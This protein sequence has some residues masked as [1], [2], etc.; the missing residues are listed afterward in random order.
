MRKIHFLSFCPRLNTVNYFCGLGICICN[1]FICLPLCIFY[2]R[3][4]QFTCIKDCSTHII[5]IRTVFFYFFRQYFQLSFHLN[6]FIL[7]LIKS[8]RKFLQIIIYLIASIS[9]S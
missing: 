3:R 4:A 7:E 2:D 6:L 1:N 8:S 9:K 5:F